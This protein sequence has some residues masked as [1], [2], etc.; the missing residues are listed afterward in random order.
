MSIVNDLVDQIS[1]DCTTLEPYVEPTPSKPSSNG[2]RKSSNPESLPYRYVPESSSNMSE[3][4]SSI[5]SYPSIASGPSSRAPSEL[6]LVTSYA[7]NRTLSNHS[8]NDHNSSVS[9]V[10]SRGT[11][12]YGRARAPV[13]RGQP[14]NTRG[15]AIQRPIDRPT[16][17][18]TVA[19]YTGPAFE[20]LMDVKEYIE[21]FELEKNYPHKRLNMKPEKLF[22]I[23]SKL[24]F[25][26]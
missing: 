16:I 23:G 24:I 7:D 9:S 2:S 20:P 5:V 12:S 19:K 13:R 15:G 8:A 6:S 4:A 10:P 14:R 22:R 21:Q 1:N 18:S 3:T 17:D 11:S 26:Y 25:Y